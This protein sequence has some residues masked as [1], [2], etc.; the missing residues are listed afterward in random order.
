MQYGADSFAYITLTGPQSPILTFDKIFQSFRSMDASRYNES[1]EIST[2]NI[3]AYL[4]DDERRMAAVQEYNKHPDGNAIKA[5]RVREILSISIHIS[6]P[7]P[8]K[9]HR[10]RWRQ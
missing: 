4:M 9:L 8:K 2:Q 10:A 5:I 3:H 1:R 7:N 6:G